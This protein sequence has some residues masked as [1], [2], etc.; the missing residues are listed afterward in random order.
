MSY[1]PGYPGFHQDY[2]EQM[3]KFPFLSHMILEN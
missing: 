2:G 3:K 1:K